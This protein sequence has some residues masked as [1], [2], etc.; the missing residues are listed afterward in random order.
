MNAGN[1]V[2]TGK[3]IHNLTDTVDILFKKFKTWEKEI[4]NLVAKDVN[5]ELRR[6]VIEIK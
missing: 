3:A 2:N 6:D 1:D 4:P 5:E